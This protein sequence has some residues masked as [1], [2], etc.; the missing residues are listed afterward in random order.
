MVDQATINGRDLGGT[1]PTEAP[2]RAIS[3]NMG[4]FAYDIAT[5]AELQAKLFSTDIQSASQ[6]AIIP[7]ALI[8]VAMGLLLS[9]LALLLVGLAYLLVQTAEL[10]P[11]AAFLIVAVTGLAICGGLV[12]EA[13]RRFMTVLEPLQRSQ[14]ELAHNA[15]WIKAVLKHGSRGFRR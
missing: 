15:S 1:S 2:G 4:D 8:A 11:A 14:R 12:W 5:L 6:R 13:R 10:S 9:S 3:K 7:V